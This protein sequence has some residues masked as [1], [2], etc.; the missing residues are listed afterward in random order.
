MFQ[1]SISSIVYHYTSLVN[2][3]N[4]LK[5]GEFRLSPTFIH[6]SNIEGNQAK[7]FFY[8]STT[9]SKQGYF[10][11]SEI[12]GVIFK[13]DGDKV[14][15]RHK[16]TQVR[17]YHDLKINDEMEDRILSD[18]PTLSISN[19]LLGID[20]LISETHQN[21]T[22]NNIAYFIYV[23][24]KKN[25]IPV[26]VYTDA[27]AMNSNNTKKSL[28][29][30]A[31]KRLKDG[32]YTPTAELRDTDIPSLIGLYHK[33]YDDLNRD[34]L[35]VRNE[36]IKNPDFHISIRRDFDTLRNTNGGVNLLKSIS[37]IL[38][39]ENLETYKEL[40][41]LLKERFSKEDDKRQKE[42]RL[43]HAKN[44]FNKERFK[45]EHILNVLRDK[46]QFDRDYLEINDDELLYMKISNMLDILEK[47][48][49][50]PE[51]IYTIW[52]DEYGMTEDGYRK[53]FNFSY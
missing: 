17:Y 43:K 49:L 7:K 18:N 44:S 37:R 5:N 8:L 19:I 25:N 23:Y 10:H 12:S 24:G 31:I 15:Q 41:H 30:D 14:N 48:D 33:K 20:V 45:Y 1:E 46:E 21:A 28:T 2:G 53:F 52:Y 29:F 50:I 51:R 35:K 26:K 22:F 34:E 9:R 4:I 27:K 11:Q 47:L 6:P 39:K 13:I 36:I 38:K 16:G 3:F 42:Q 40:V 32:K